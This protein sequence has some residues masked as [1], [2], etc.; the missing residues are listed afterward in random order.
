MG[1]GR[2]EIV[3]DYAAPSWRDYKNA[4]FWFRKVG[5]RLAGGRPVEF[6]ARSAVAEHARYLE[7]MGFEPGESGSDG[8][9][10]YT[11]RVG[12]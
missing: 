1:E 4:E 2:I 10:T 8:R 11:K 7:R 5:E 6:T 3:L 9:R 12:A